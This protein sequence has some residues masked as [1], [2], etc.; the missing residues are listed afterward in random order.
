MPSSDVA[1]L[2]RGRVA[3]TDGPADAVFDVVAF[4]RRRLLAA[5]A[6]DD[7]L[8]VFY[9]VII[10]VDGAGDVLGEFGVGGGLVA[11]DNS[12]AAAGAF[13]EVLAVDGAIAADGGHGGD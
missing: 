13:V 10:T 5:S 1:T 7:N 12:I 11:L 9:L 3:F 6:G 8:L 2:A 4:R